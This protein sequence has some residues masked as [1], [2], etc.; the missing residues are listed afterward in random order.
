MTDESVMETS[1]L[2]S[3]FWYLNGKLHREGGPAVVHLNGSKEW[4]LNDRL[5]REDGPAVM[6]VSGYA[7]WWVRGWRCTELGH[8]VFVRKQNFLIST[9]EVK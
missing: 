2:G 3:E 1:S 6:Y 8:A 9:L 4:Y 7:E 5:H